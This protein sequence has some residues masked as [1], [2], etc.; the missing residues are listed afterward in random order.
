MNRI[1]HIMD[2][3]DHYAMTFG[4]NR[5][6]APNRQALRAAIEKALADNEELQQLNDRLAD[7]LKRTAIALRGPEPELTAWS[8]HDLPERVVQAINACGPG[9]G[10]LHKAARIEA[11]EQELAT[12]KDSLTAQEPVAYTFTRRRLD[13]YKTRQFLWADDY[14]D[15]P[16]DLK[17]VLDGQD[18]VVI[19]YT[20]PNPQPKPLFA[21][22]EAL[23]QTMAEAL[24]WCP[25]G[26]HAQYLLK[27][28][29]ARAGENK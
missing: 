23:R 17:F 2:L 22:N 4:D 10:C 14:K 24:R 28:A 25:D 16:R 11:L 7:I 15:S 6:D 12:I 9:A 18:D 3:A 20:T 5:N 26:C 27:T 8:W 13:G 1:D 29:L 21:E 19:L